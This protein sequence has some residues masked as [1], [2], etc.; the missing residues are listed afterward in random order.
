MT[1]TFTSLAALHGHVTHTESQ[2]RESASHGIGAASDVLL[3]ERR[4]SSDTT[5]KRAVRTRRGRRYPRKRS[6]SSRGVTI[7]PTNRRW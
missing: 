2:L 1:R 6:R 7:R 3:G 5:K 4:K